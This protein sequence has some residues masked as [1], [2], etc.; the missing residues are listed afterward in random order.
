[1]TELAMRVSALTT[2]LNLVSRQDRSRIRGWSR[3]ERLDRRRLRL[4]PSDGATVF[5]GEG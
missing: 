2:P 4:L 5:T 1:M 3:G